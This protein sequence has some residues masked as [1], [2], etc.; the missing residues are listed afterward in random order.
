VWAQVMQR[1][2]HVILQGRFRRAVAAEGAQT[3]Q[4]FDAP[5]HNV[6][7]PWVLALLA[8]C[9][10]SISAS[11]QVAVGDSPHVLTPLAAGAHAITVSHPGTEPARRLH[12]HRFASSPVC[13]T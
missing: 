1:K 13:S 5:F 8:R 9:I 3:G 2:S 7:A 12:L 6:P 11:T 10:S 4:R